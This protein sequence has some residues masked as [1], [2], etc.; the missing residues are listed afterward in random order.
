MPEDIC[1]PVARQCLCCVQGPLVEVEPVL[2]QVKEVC[3]VHRTGG[4]F[5]VL[6]CSYLAQDGEGAVWYSPG[7]LSG[8]GF[9]YIYV[10]LCEVV[11]FSVDC[12][13]LAWH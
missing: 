9:N 3:A 11:P 2:F 1:H 6:D 12:I 5:R 7:G 13:A 10:I 4:G 8:N